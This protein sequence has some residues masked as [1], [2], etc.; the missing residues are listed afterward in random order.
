MP[1]H[2][3]AATLR[4]APFDMYLCGPPPMVD[5]VKTWLADNGIDNGHLYF[6]KFTESNT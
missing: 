3:D 6:E 1:E 2:F 4:E 5:S